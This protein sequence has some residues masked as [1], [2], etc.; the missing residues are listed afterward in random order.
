[1]NCRD[2]AMFPGNI[3]SKRSFGGPAA[4]LAYLARYTHRVAISNS[5]LIAL[6]DGAVTFK[7]KDYRIKGTTRTALSLQE[8]WSERRIGSKDRHPSTDHARRR[9][10]STPSSLESRT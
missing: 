6:Q 1:M 5:R 9:I 8:Y 7:W 3:R 2:S 10:L 4:V